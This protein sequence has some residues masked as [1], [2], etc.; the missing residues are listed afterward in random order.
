[1]NKN[2]YI[3]IIIALTISLIFM[4]FLA[5]QWHQMNTIK[6]H[7]ILLKELAYQEQICNLQEKLEYPVCSLGD[8]LIEFDSD[9]FDVASCQAIFGIGEKSCTLSN[10]TKIINE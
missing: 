1:M 6:P 10:G 3:I 4:S 5:Y 7:F 8:K 9:Y 2:Y